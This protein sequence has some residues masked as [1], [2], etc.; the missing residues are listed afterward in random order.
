MR[1]NNK[2][3]FLASSSPRRAEILT[4][5]GIFFRIISV[6]VPEIASENEICDEYV[7]RLAREKAQVG[8]KS[9]SEEDLVV[10]GADTVILL[11]NQILEKPINEQDAFNMLA[12][13]SNKTHLVKT[14]VSVCSRIKCETVVQTSQVTMADLSSSEISAY[15]QSGEPCGKAGGY[16]VQGKGAM[17]IKHIEGSYSGIMGLPIYETARLLNEFEVR[18]NFIN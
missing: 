9:R 17:F 11:D 18:S 3:V 14:A 6:S 16:A 8:V 1:S 12:S 10:I 4:Q 7:Y 2:Q 15:W 13:L 5:M